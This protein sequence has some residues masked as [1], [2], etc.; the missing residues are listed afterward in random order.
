MKKSVMYAL[1]ALATSMAVNTGIGNIH[2]NQRGKAK[3]N[4]CDT[5]LCCPG[6]SC[7]DDC[8]DFCC[9]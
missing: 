4:S 2:F 5:S 9:E 1:F 3:N 8:C 7:S 6:G